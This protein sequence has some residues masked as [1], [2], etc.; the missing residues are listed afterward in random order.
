ML[1]RAFVVSSAVAGF[2]AACSG[3]SGDTGSTQGASS[4]GAT[5]CERA[6]AA[7]C[8]KAC[9]CGC[10]TGYQSEYG[11]TTFTWSDVGDCKAAYTQ[12]KDG[13]AAGVD[14]DACER[15]TNA[16]SCTGDVFAIPKSCNPPKKDGG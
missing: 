4:A 14:W 12:C 10:K 11:T 8:E 3:G 2:I 13:G 1:L 6:G 7:A 9:A 15:D 5:A 16:A